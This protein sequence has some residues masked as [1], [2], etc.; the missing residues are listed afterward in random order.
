MF[1]IA[2]MVTG[3]EDEEGFG[4]T[5]ERED[6]DT[7]AEESEESFPEYP[8]RAS[9]SITKVRSCLLVIA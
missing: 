9:F 3:E 1:S 5:E 7:A 2:D 6:G 4:Q 8:I